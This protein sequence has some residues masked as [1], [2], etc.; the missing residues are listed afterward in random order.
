MTMRVALMLRNIDERGGVGEYARRITPALVGLDRRN[1]YL[2]LYRSREA[3]E[4]HPVDS[5]RPVV[6]EA[7]TKLLWDQVA[8]PRALA[9]EGVDVALGIKH[10]I[11]L[12]TPARKVFIMHGSDWISFRE[13]YTPLDNLYHDVMLPR[14]LAAADRV[15]AVS[16]D[17]ECRIGVHAGG[18]GQAPGRL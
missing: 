16:H 3:A 12:A 8:V 7:P 10:S 1:E 11:P 2:L 15:I 5:A 9:R 6:V 17:R 14:Y 18:A 4:Q 13:N